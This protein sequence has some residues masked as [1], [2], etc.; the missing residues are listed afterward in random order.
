MIEQ[1]MG[2]AMLGEGKKH[3]VEPIDTGKA[4]KVDGRA[5]RVWEV[6]RNGELDD[7][8]RS[9]PLVHPRDCIGQRASVICSASA[10]TAGSPLA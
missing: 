10:A 2:S 6:K 8:L 9:L 3:T 7:Q 4:D 5:C 1:Q